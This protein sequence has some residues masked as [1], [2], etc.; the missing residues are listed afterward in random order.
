M[1]KNIDGDEWYYNA[2]GRC[3]SMCNREVVVGDH[4]INSKCN[5]VMETIVPRFRLKV[6]VSLGKADDDIK[7]V[8]FEK[9]VADQIGRSSSM[10]LESIREVCMFS[11]T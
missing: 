11:S 1:F 5:V 4:C 7:L 2:C 3:N 9:L 6:K 10:V 8:M